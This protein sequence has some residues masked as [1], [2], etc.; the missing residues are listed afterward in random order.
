MLFNEIYSN[1]FNLIAK[2]ISTSVDGTLDNK[3]LLDIVN[4]DGFAES[5]VVVPDA[6]KDK[7]WPLITSTWDTPLKSKPTMP[8]S[9]LQK[10]WLK[11]LISDPRIA[12]FGPDITGLEDVEPLYSSDSIVYFDQY[13]DGDPYTDPTYIQNFRTILTALKDKKRLKLVFTSGH[14]K[15]HVWEDIPYKLEYSSKD[16]KF[17]LLVITKKDMVPI[18]VAR[19]EH[20]SVMWEYDESEYKV[21]GLQKDE[22]T[23]ELVDERNAL[24]RVMLAFSNLEKVTEKLDD[25]HYKVT[26]KY[27]KDDETEILIRIMSFGPMIKVI[28]PDSFIN[29]I[30]ERLIMQKRFASY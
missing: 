6:I 30:K 22:L 12:L 2:I 25:K 3:V 23:F 14:G 11:A 17:R 21:W 18:N 19:I 20:C 4:S 27:V 7:S 28:S 1:Y 9:T 10:R 26:L 16:D 13:L 29:Q 8:L 15:R 5:K 24:E